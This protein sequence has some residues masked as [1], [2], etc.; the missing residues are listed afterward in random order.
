MP[1]VPDL[2]RGGCISPFHD[3]YDV[4]WGGPHGN[5]NA[6]AD[7]DHGGMDS[8]VAQSE[9]G[10]KCSRA[11][12]S[13]SCRPC[14]FSVRECDVMGCHEGSDIPNYY[15]TYADDFVLQDHLFE[16]NLSYSLPAHLYE[17]SERSA[18]CRSA[19]NP[20]SCVNSVED[21]NRV[22]GLPPGSTTPVCAWTDLT[23]LLHKD[24]ISWAYYVL[25]G[26]EPDCEVDS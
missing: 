5:Q 12:G 21:P 7:I 6:V 23:R 3:P 20:M 8:F 24:G 13:P 9:I 16:S 2:S 1:C 22:Q 26:T 14:R 10:H 19:D 4:N 17:V 11:T 25:R 18:Y 15:W